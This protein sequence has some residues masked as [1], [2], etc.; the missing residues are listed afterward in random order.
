MVYFFLIIFLIFGIIFVYSYDIISLLLPL[1]WFQYY[2]YGFIFYNSCLFN[3]N[4]NKFIHLFLLL[5]LVVIISQMV[6]ILGGIYSH[7]YIGNVKDRPS[8]LMGGS[9][10]MALTSS[11]LGLVLI[12]SNL[13]EKNY[14]ISIYLLT[15][16]FMIVYLTGTKTGLFALLIAFILLSKKHR[17]TFIFILILTLIYI[18]STENTF[19][20]FTNYYFFIVSFWYEAWL[21]YLINFNLTNYFFGLGIGATGI[22]VDGLYAKAYLDGGSN[23]LFIHIFYSDSNIPYS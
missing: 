22:A 8:G 7:G 1:K 14:L 13:E 12:K 15:L 20:Y 9:W 4:I 6:G 2:V 23:I 3:R 5:N 18:F 19:N 17:F 11:T 10:E 21:E 16:T